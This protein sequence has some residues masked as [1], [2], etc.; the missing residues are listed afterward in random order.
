MDSSGCKVHGCGR[1]HCAKGHCSAHYKQARKGRAP[2]AIKSVGDDAVRFWAKVERRSEDQ[3]WPWLAARD[4][5]G[6]GVFYLGARLTKAPR[7]SWALLVGPIPEGLNV[8]HRCD[9]PQCVN[10]AHLFLGTQADNLLDMRTKGRADGNHNPTRLGERHHCAKLTWAK[11]AEAR[12]RHAA[13]EGLSALA[14]EFN[15]TPPTMWAALHHR[16]WKKTG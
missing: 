8:L 13:G 2:S 1:P 4:D 6:Y 15:V 11:V 10:P 3:C 5:K 9:N 16:T 12:A 7:A 14:R